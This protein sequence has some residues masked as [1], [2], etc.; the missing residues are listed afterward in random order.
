MIKTHAGV[1]EGIGAFSLAAQRCGIKTEWTCEI[2]HWRKK[3]LRKQF[4]DVKQHNDIR[5]LSYP[6]PVDVLTGGFPC[7]DISVAGNFTGIIGEQSRLWYEYIRVIHEVG[8]RYV[9]IENSVQLKSKGLEFILYD[10]AKAGYD[11]Q[12]QVL[13]AEQF[14][15]PHKRERLFIV[16][17]AAEIGRGQKRPV[18]I[19][20]K[21][22][23]VLE[24]PYRQIVLPMQI[25]RIKWDSDSS[26]VRMCHGLSARMD[27]TRISA[28][29]DAIIP[30]IAE[31]I[32]KCIIKFDSQLTP[33]TYLP[34]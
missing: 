32:L 27:R 33:L 20:Q 23:D 25:K 21:I 31:Y 34:A 1:F 9:I 14:G 10:L 4:P 16:A 3:I 15:Y 6:P 7:Q 13:S 28:I 12:W 2:N 17:Y 8:P 24:R 29:G 5:K 19:F 26:D 22:T 30:D 11:A 18:Q